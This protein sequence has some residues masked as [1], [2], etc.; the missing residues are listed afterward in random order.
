MFVAIA[1][2][3]L[4]I[5]D[6]YRFAIIK[7]QLVLLKLVLAEWLLFKVIAIYNLNLFTI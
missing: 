1:K 7:I 2:P 6:P 4:T 3:P 5:S